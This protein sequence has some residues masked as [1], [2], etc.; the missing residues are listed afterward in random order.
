MKKT[1]VIV[2]HPDIARS[3][4]NR[5]WARTLAAQVWGGGY[6]CTGMAGGKNGEKLYQVR[7]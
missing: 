1:L 3:T 7:I 4:V 5:T 6:F 2:A